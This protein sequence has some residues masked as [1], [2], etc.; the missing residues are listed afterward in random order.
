MISLD[1]GSGGLAVALYTEAVLLLN[2]TS[3]L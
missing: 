1:L 2:M 3:G